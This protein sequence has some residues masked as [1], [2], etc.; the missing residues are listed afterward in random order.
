MLS[1]FFFVLFSIPCLTSSG[2]PF[3]LVVYSPPSRYS[4]RLRIG[5]TCTNSLY[6]TTSLSMSINVNK[7]MCRAFAKVMYFMIVIACKLHSLRLL[8]NL[9]EKYRSPLDGIIALRSS[10]APLSNVRCHV[11]RSFFYTLYLYA[12]CLRY[13]VI[14][15]NAYSPQVIHCL[16]LSWTFAVENMCLSSSARYGRRIPIITANY[17]H[18]FIP[19]VVKFSMVL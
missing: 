6:Y 8:A 17:I 2:W 4:S 18:P 15:A 16:L 19:Y 12:H 11:I 1:S 7:R 14:L 9:R 13:S 10:I 5:G 3:F